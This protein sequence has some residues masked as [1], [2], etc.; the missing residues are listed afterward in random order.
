MNSVLTD[1]CEAI[2]YNATRDLQAWF[3]GRDLYVPIKAVQSHPLATLLGMPT[4]R[5]LVESFGAQILKIPTDAADNWAR[6]DRRIAELFAAGMSAA[7]VAG[8]VDLSERRVQQIRDELVLRG[9]LQ[10][11]AGPGPRRGRP[12]APPV[13]LGDDAEKMGTSAVF[14]RPPGVD[15]EDDGEQPPRPGRGLD[16]GRAHA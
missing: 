14:Q 15:G 4:F 13:L 7:Y 2:G 1:V 3:P 9:W 16:A 12:A 10:Y 6:R 5:L 8:A 11:A